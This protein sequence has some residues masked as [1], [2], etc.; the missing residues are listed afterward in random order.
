MDIRH[1]GMENET[2]N[3]GEDMDFKEIDKQFR[4]INP[5]PMWLHKHIANAKEL[6]FKSL[7]EAITVMMSDSKY[8]RLGKIQN[9]VGCGDEVFTRYRNVIKANGVYLPDRST[10]IKMKGKGRPRVEANVRAKDLFNNIPE[11]KWVMPEVELFGDVDA[12]R[13]MRR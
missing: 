12:F 13:G 5:R 4:K 6:G 9:M 8:G 7:A 2:K 1:S 10:G 11:D 3:N